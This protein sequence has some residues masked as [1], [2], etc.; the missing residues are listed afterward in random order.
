MFLHQNLLI[1]EGKKINKN[2]KFQMRIN[3]QDVHSRAM[4]LTQTENGLMRLHSKYRMA[5]L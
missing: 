2:W 5:H 4:I 3:L 1:T